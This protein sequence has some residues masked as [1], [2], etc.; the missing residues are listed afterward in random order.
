MSQIPTPPRPGLIPHRPLTQPAA[1]AYG[2]AL[3]LERSVPG[4]GSTFVLAL[5]RRVTQAAIRA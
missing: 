1:S 3:S 2:G 4:K 5:P